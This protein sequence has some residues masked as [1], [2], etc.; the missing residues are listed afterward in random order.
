MADLLIVDDDDDTAEA[1]SELLAC[2][3]HHVRIAHDG[4][5]GLARLRE[6][7]PDLILLD[8]EMPRLS[9]PEMAYRLFLRDAGDE[10]IPIILLSGR[11]DLRQ[12]AAVVGTPYFLS[13]PYGLEELLTLLRRALVERTR[14]RPAFPAPSA[15]P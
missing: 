2:D 11:L 14:P 13:K 4:L 10:E 12:T 8:V 15:R 1:L 5:E 9:G 6:A 3:G 7:R